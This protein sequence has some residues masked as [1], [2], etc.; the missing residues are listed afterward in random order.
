MIKKNY[1]LIYIP[2]E[3]NQ[4]VR[5][6]ER[7]VH[8]KIASLEIEKNFDSSTLYATKKLQFMF[9]CLAVFYKI[10]TITYAL[11]YR[12]VRKTVCK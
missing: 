3:K 10:M 6:F 5:Q 12:K 7:N 11:F 1:H 8:C 4:F 2:Q 9:L